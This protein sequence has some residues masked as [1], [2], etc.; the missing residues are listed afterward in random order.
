MTEPQ[1]HVPLYKCDDCEWTGTADD[2]ADHCSATDDEHCAFHRIDD[3]PI[4]G[5]PA[6][7]PCKHRGE[8]LDG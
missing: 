5:T 6:V 7:L 1:E 4:C 3:C 2:A 8:V